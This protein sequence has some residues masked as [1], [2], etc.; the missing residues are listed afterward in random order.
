MKKICKQTRETLGSLK[1]VIK[2][3]H[4]K[5]DITKHNGSFNVKV[6]ENCKTAVNSMND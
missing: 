3:V 2:F 6:R 5:H 4:L 1:K